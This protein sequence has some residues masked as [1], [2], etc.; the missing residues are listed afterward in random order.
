[1]K[2]LFSSVMF[3]SMPS[4]SYRVV[5]E[6]EPIPRADDPNAERHRREARKFAK[7]IGLDPNAEEIALC[8]SGM[9]PE[10]YEHYVKVV[11]GRV[12]DG[13]SD[14][15]FFDQVT[16]LHAELQAWR[17]TRASRRDSRPRRVHVRRGPSRVHARTRRAARRAA[18][19]DGPGRLAADDDDL[20]SGAGAAR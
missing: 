7:S 15:V 10:L 19:R 11:Q 3:S 4:L 12:E 16:Q 17:A 14:G 6:G 5:V 18:S 2:G 20:D 8:L 9:S 13:R 1:M